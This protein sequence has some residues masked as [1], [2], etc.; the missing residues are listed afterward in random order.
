MPADDNINIKYH[1]EGL[2]LNNR[3]AIQRQRY[4]SPFLRGQDRL[5]ASIVYRCCGCHDRRGVMLFAAA[6]QHKD[7]DGLPPDNSP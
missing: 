4:V 5:T 7:F 3:R 1:S 6:V 2:K